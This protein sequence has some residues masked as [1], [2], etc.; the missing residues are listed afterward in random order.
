MKLKILLIFLVATMATGISNAADFVVNG[1]SYNY[2]ESDNEVELTELVENPLLGTTDYPAEVI[3][4]ETVEYKGKTY[5]VVAIGDK[6]FYFS[7]TVEK[8]TLPESITRI[9]EEAFANAN[10][11]SEVNIPAGVTYI[12]ERAFSTCPKI[13]SLVIPEGLKELPDQLLY[14]C[15]G[16]RQL[17]LPSTLESIGYASLRFCRALTSISIPSGVKEIGQLAFA[18]CSALENIE[19]PANLEIIGESAFT[20]CEELVAI[21]FPASV[22]SYGNSICYGCIKL[23]KAQL[24]ETMIAIPNYMFYQCSSLQEI[25][26]PS[27]ITSIGN[28]SF[29]YSGLKSLTIP[30]NVLEIGTQA[31]DG[32]ASLRTLCFENG[33]EDLYIGKGYLGKPMFSDSSDINTLVYG[34]NFVYEVTPLTTLAKIKNLTIGEF[35]TDVNA[36]TPSKNINLTEITVEAINPPVINEFDSFVY[37][38]AKLIIPANTKSLY[39]NAPVWKNFINIEEMENSSI[40][41]IEADKNN[42]AK[43]Y[44]LNGNIV[45]NPQKG[46]FIKVTDNNSQKIIL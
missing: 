7:D 12:G 4:P 8:I 10:L 9:G 18:Q 44:D 33:N 36:I 30:S 21:S 38:T 15:R 17:T 45:K 26:I 39:E 43:F 28:Y 34:R 32:I 40:S 31:F 41:G 13:K 29:E 1:L 3:V 42:N 20:G 22:M 27:S 14:S 37:E 46:I 2:L 16:L 23:E 11:L 24:P 6:A 5:N 25:S 19:L 35:I